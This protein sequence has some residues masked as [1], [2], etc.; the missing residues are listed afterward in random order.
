MPITAGRC[1]SC[2]AQPPPGPG[3][4]A[5]GLYCSNACRQ[6]AYRQHR[7]A[8]AAAQEARPGPRP[9]TIPLALDSFVGRA[10]ELAAVR[11]LLR[12]S[13][14][15]TLFGPAGVGKTRLALELAG[16]VG[17]SFPGGV[18]LVELGP[19]TRPEVVGRAVASTLGVCEQPGTPLTDTLVARVQDDEL[20]LVLDNC[21]HLI[22]ACGSLVVL[23]LRRC[24]GLHILATSREAL[25]LPGELVFA[26]DQL[27]A[28]DA[29][30]L[31]ADRAR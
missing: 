22:E 28:P 29:A 25:R 10:A 9:P 4:S 3:S 6:R 12:T 21:E 24:A 7:R 30:Q 31:F 8:A 23:L 15:I 16:R 27:P 2:G 14:L 18:H 17:L 19:L 5:H 11:R 13:R 26:S 1:A 20:L